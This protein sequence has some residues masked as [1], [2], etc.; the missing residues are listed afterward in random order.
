MAVFVR[1]QQSEGRLSDGRFS[2]HAAV[3][4]A[5]QRWLLSV[6]C[7][8]TRRPLANGP[9]FRVGDKLGALSALAAQLR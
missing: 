9:L 3:S 4:L 1:Q 5:K 8:Q 2:G 6:S 7:L